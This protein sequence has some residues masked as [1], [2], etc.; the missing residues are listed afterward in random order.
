MIKSYDIASSLELFGLRKDMKIA[1]VD[2]DIDAN[3]TNSF[4]ANT[5]RNNGYFIHVFNEKDSAVKWLNK[6]ILRTGQS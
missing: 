2:V 1:F 5:A 3:K 6:D 4:S